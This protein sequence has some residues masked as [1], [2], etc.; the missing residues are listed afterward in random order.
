M[1]T[2]DKLAGVKHDFTKIF[3]ED[4]TTYKIT[5]TAKLKGYFSLTGE[6]WSK[7]RNGK[8]VEDRCGCIHDDIAKHFPKLR[9]LIKW[10]LCGFNEPMHY[11]ANTLYHASDKD[12]WGLRKGER[13]QI[14]NGKTGVPCWELVAVVDGVS[15]PIHE[16]KR[17]R[18]SLTKPENPPVLE[19]ASWD[20]I[21]EGKERDFDAARS[22]A[23]W[24]EATDEEL[25]APDLEDRLKAR[26]PA[27]MDEFHRAMSAL[28]EK[29]AV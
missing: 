28:F 22:T 26:L 16:L 14:V 3:T 2:Y 6:V 11:I 10:H 4:G 20:R 25:M 18:D 21:G 19:W 12:C 13:R 5:A 27:L 8:W 9:P 24:P 17:Y 15:M 23:V 7:S 1:S 29:E